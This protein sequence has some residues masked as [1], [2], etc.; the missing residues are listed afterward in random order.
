MLTHILDEYSILTT[1]TKVTNSYT[2]MIINL[3]SLQTL[4]YSMM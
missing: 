4:K 1:N 3:N 2:S